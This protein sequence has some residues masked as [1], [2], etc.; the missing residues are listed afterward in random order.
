MGQKPKPSSIVRVVD[1]IGRLAV[2]EAVQEAMTRWVII[3]DSGEYCVC[4]NESKPP[5]VYGTFT[6]IEEAAALVK[7]KRVLDA[8]RNI[9]RKHLGYDLLRQDDLWA[10]YRKCDD[11]LSTLDSVHWCLNN[12]ETL[13]R[14]IKKKIKLTDFMKKKVNENK[15]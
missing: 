4:D 3:Y 9:N 10:T 2:F 6:K 12:T 1:C 14:G 15:E 11:S 5:T 8:L 7:R 13:W